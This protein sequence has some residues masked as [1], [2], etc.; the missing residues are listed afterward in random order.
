GRF[1]AMHEKFLEM[2]MESPFAEERFVEMAKWAEEAEKHVT[3]VIDVGGYGN[4]SR[5]ALI[6]HATQVD[7]TSKHWFGLPPDVADELF[8]YDHYTLARDLTGRT[9]PAEPGDKEDDL[10]AGLTD[11]AASY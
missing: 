4:V 2:G 5:R 9:A 6:A 7:P 1:R 3:T 10:F 11:A 8:P